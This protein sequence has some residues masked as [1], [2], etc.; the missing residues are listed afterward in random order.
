MGWVKSRP[1]DGPNVTLVQS[2][3]QLDKANAA[4][5]IT[6]RHKQAPKWADAAHASGMTWT[7]EIDGRPAYIVGIVPDPA[8]DPV[9]TVSVI[10]HEAVH[11][12]QGWFA[13]IAEDKPSDEFQ[14]YVIQ[15][16]TATLLSQYKPPKI[17]A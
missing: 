11:V 2:A 8:L 5:G 14:A 9:S 6:H 16:I 4:L 17:R 3:K 12:A 15:A 10:V 13:D 7:L 1:F